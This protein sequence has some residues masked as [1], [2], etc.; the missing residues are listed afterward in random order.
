MRRKPATRSNPLNRLEHLEDRTTPT[1]SLVSAPDPTIGE[2]PNGNSFAPSLS[3]DGSTVAFASEASNMVAGDTNTYTD[4][5]MKN[6]ATGT[7]VRI[8]LAADGTQANGNS[9]N[10]VF[11][12]DGKKVA[13]ESDATNLVSG[14]TT[15]YREIFIK[16]L[17][18]GVVTLAST[19]A[20]GN[21]G[22]GFAFRPAFSPDGA[23]LYFDSD[24]TNLVA[25]D[26]NGQRDVFRKNLTTG[27][28]TLIST[29]ASGQ[30]LPYMTYGAIPSPDGARVAY[31]ASTTLNNQL[32]PY[33]VK[34]LATGSQLV[35]S[36]PLRGNDPMHGFAFSP[37]G[38]QIAYSAIVSKT[39]QH[40]TTEFVVYLQDLATNQTQTLVNFTYNPAPYAYDDSNALGGG[41]AFDRTGTVLFVSSPDNPTVA[42]DTN[43]TDDIYSFTFSTN[44]LTRETFAPG[45]V[46]SNRTSYHPVGGEG[47]QFVF[48]S[49]ASNLLAPTSLSSEQIYL[50]GPTGLPTP[51]VP[52]SPPYTPPAPPTS[53]TP[54]VVN[55][56]ADQIVSNGFGNVDIDV[57][58]PTTPPDQLAITYHSDPRLSFHFVGTGSKRL[59]QI[60]TELPGFGH[61]SGSLTPV[62]FSVKDRDGAVT[63]VVFSSSV[64]FPANATTT[65][66]TST[67]TVETPDIT[68]VTV[69]GTQAQL[70]HF[71]ARSHGKVVFDRTLPM[72]YDP[73]NLDIQAT[74]V[75]MRQALIDSGT[76]VIT[77]PV[78]GAPHSSS[79]TDVHVI[80]T[81][82]TT[83]DPTV[84]ATTYIGPLIVRTGFNQSEFAYII[85][86]GIYV[87][88]LLTYPVT[89]H[90][91]RTTTTNTT[92]TTD[93][94]QSD[95]LRLRAV[96]VDGGEP[97]VR[98]F[99]PEGTP[100]VDDL[101]FET[102][103][104]GGV[105][106]AT[107]DVTGDGI[108][109]VFAAAGIGGGPR[110]RILDGSTGAS[111]RD[112]FAFEPE[113]HGGI[114]VAAGDLNGDGVADYAVGAGLGGGPRVAV[115]DGRSGARLLDFYTFDAASRDGVTVAIG[116]VNGDGQAEIV[117]GKLS[118]GSEVRVFNIT[119]NQVGE[120]TTFEPSFTG[121]VFVAVGDL[122]GDGHLDLIAG[123]GL[124]GG[125]RV[126][127]FQLTT[128]GNTTEVGNQFIGDPSLRSGIR[129]G[130]GETV[131]GG[132]LLVAAPG[133]GKVL[134]IT[135]DGSDTTE[136]PFGTGYTGGVWVS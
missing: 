49:V 57:S 106:V 61:S 132:T 74:V 2:L 38:S 96:G 98:A 101:V 92:T 23:S 26:T 109:D 41:I 114:F 28:V 131:A 62:T 17:A 6:L 48:S 100:A 122:N 76:T 67:K 93:V 71:L 111:V 126:R 72:P 63:S 118:G 46:Q 16:D 8:S 65:A 37:D 123:A 3:P 83:G 113:F 134:S 32:I 115:F 50:S 15:T 43:N 42:G 20:A 64:G 27:A 81:G 14:D 112:F 12:P 121:G 97:R 39:P 82:R 29:D 136:T 119:G 130:T 125:P 19:D 87:D 56:E 11:S 66:G 69:P 128:N 47:N 89:V 51:T 13:F 68:D 60:G 35:V 25:G 129:V 45:G 90:Q 22:E 7:V 91:T 52:A 99:A 103:F 104:T 94:T 107:G 59:I 53:L 54:P 31:T 18:T 75:A 5:F 133:Y 1:V 127:A 58:S 34:T 86:G 124:G 36:P 116:D 85:P 21:P 24:A 135:S 9:F 10:P 117:V 30:Q 40:L 73:A 4:I 102:K 110:V 84:V 105:R 78:V 79:T 70:T 55:F 80:E 120:V 95:G 77:S 33:V 108:D 88:A 44:T